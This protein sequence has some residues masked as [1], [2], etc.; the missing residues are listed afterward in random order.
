[1]KRILIVDDDEHLPDVLADLLSQEGRAVDMA[2]D[3]SEALALLDQH[4]YDV[5]LSDLRMRHH[6][7]GRHTTTLPRVIF[8]TGNAGDAEYADFLKGTTEP[9]LEKPFS[10]KVVKQVVSVLLDGQEIT[11]RADAAS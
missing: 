4:H 7:P 11:I 3:G 10:L 8:M 2:R 5:I 6:S 9:M 1:M